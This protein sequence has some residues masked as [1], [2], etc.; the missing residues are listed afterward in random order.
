MAASPP[1]IGLCRRFTAGLAGIT[2]RLEGLLAAWQAAN[3]QQE[4]TPVLSQGR[5]L[6]PPAR[7]VLGEYRDHHHHQG[8]DS[9]Q[10]INHK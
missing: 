8:E 7:H 1:G 5:A 3:S 9:H 2:T 10:A 4:A 6:F